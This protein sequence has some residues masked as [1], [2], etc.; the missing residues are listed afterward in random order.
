[1]RLPL[2]LTMWL[3]RRLRS[4]S[5]RAVGK[6]PPEEM[7]MQVDVVVELSQRSAA[8]ELVCGHAHRWRD[9]I[10]GDGV[11]WVVLDAFGGERDCLRIDSTGRLEGVCSGY[12]DGGVA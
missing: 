12:E 1:M 9:E 11:R 2:S 6:K 4:G 10:V 8:R 3:A 7:A 5:K